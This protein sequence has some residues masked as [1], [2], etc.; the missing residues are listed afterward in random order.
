MIKISMKMSRNRSANTNVHFAKRKSV[1]VNQNLVAE[2][3]NRLLP[4][5][6]RHKQAVTVQRKA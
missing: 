1:A 2:S 3:L 5:R 4:F 6:G